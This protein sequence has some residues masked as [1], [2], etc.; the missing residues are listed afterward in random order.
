MVLQICFFFLMTFFFIQILVNIQ[1]NIGHNDHLN[2][3]HH[4]LLIMHNFT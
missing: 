2:D 1:Y 3:I 4:F